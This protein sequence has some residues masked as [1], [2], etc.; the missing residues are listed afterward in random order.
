MRACL[1]VQKRGWCGSL[2]TKK[3]NKHEKAVAELPKKKRKISNIQVPES[4][5]RTYRLGKSL[6][7]TAPLL[8]FSCFKLKK[9]QSF[10][11]VWSAVWN[12]FPFGL[13]VK[14]KLWSLAIF[15][16]SYH[17][18]ATQLWLN[19][20]KLSHISLTIML[21]SLSS[22][23]RREYETCPLLWIIIVLMRFTE[24]IKTKQCGF[25]SGLKY[26]GHYK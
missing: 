6:F 18:P 20:G 26:F 2:F 23:S 13:L 25:K 24:K 16:I 8:S 19:D 10:C 22:Q 12:R 3:T 9:F 17:F 7:Q 14:F 15:E 5:K 4:E 21:R 11:Q 1:N